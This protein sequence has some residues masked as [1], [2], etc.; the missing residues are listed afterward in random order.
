MAKTIEIVHE[1][2]GTDR[3]HFSA[4]AVPTIGRDRKAEKITR[5]RPATELIDLLSSGSRTRVFWMTTESYV[6]LLS[7]SFL[8]VV[9]IPVEIW[10]SLEKVYE[11]PFGAQLRAEIEYV[12]AVRRVLFLEPLQ[13]IPASKFETDLGRFIDAASQLLNNFKTAGSPDYIVGYDDTVFA[14]DAL[15]NLGS[16]L[17]RLQARAVEV[18]NALP[19]M[20]MFR[21]LR[22][23]D[24]WISW[25]TQ[26][27]S[28]HSLSVSASQGSDKSPELVPPSPFVHAIFLL[29][30]CI[31]PEGSLGVT[32]D[33]YD[34]TSGPS[35][36]LSKEINRARAGHDRT[37][38][39]SDS[40]AYWEQKCRFRERFKRFRYR[41]L[42]S[43]LERALSFGG[44][45]DK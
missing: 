43:L 33:D 1:A 22:M 30:S 45:T 39:F 15:D 36:S 12:C 9:A 37:L 23:H 8:P 40:L 10:R 38:S 7:G 16:E 6:P 13:T 5:R 14:D 41:E 44:G 25:L 18:F 28:S 21:K 20:Y 19:S 17:P 35:W 29:N 24:V 27:F 32:P 2:G 31:R 3:I 42:D 4:L 11:V 34:Y 26:V